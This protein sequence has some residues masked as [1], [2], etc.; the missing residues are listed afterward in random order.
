VSAWSHLREIGRPVGRLATGAF[1]LGL[2][3]APA[4]ALAAP[5]YRY[6]TVELSGTGSGV[7]RTITGPGGV[8]DNQVDCRIVNGYV[9]PREACSQQFDVG[10]DGIERLFYQ[11]IPATGSCRYATGCLETSIE[12]YIDIDQDAV[13]TATFNLVIYPVTVTKSGAGMVTSDA[14]GILCGSFCSHDWAYGTAL[15]LTAKPDIGASF[16]GWTGACAGQDATCDLVVGG[17]TTTNATFVLV[18]APTPTPSAAATPRATK[19]PAAGT[20]APPPPTAAPETATPDGSTDTASVGPSD[21]ATAPASAAPTT[22]PSVPVVARAGSD[23]LPIVLAIL[24]AGLFI[25]IAVGIVG[26][27][28]TRQPRSPG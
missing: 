13:Y 12:T 14:D 6:L 1:A 24:G 4:S 3:F 22:D 25:A 8:P 23:L 27:R 9:D 18:G 26:F 5:N 16:A 20:A 21:S 17:A 7:F 2:A 19:G 11:L 15:V 28:M 10:D